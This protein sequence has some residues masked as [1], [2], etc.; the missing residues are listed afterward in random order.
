MS[1]FHGAGLDDRPAVVGRELRVGNHRL[2]A[3]RAAAGRRVGDRRRGSATSGARARRL[4]SGGC[5]ASLSASQRRRAAAA[6]SNRRPRRRRAATSAADRRW[7]RSGPAAG[8]TPPARRAAGR[9][10][11][12][13]RRRR[14]GSSPYSRAS[15][16]PARAA[17]RPGC[18]AL[19]QLVE[20]AELDRLGRARLRAGRGL[21]V[22][23]PVVAQRALL[24]EAGVLG[25]LFDRSGGRSPRTGRR[26][27]VAAAVA[28]V[29]LHDDRAELGPEQ[30][31]RR[32]DVQAGGVVQ[33]LQT[34]GRHQPAEL[35]P[36]AGASGLAAPGGRTSACRARPVGGRACGC[37][38]KAT[39]RQVLALSRPVLSYELPSRSKPSVRDPVP[40]LAGHLAGLAA[41]ADGGV[42]EE[43]LTRRRCCPAGVERPGSVEPNG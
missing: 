29:V 43:A 40:L 23:E 31:A 26:H 5:S 32:A 34:F 9:T 13:R 37:S 35:G 16:T 28:D 20:R 22:A 15:V 1:A 19:P 14:S 24:R 38:M 41:D 18:G 25:A 36:L 33:C 21:V 30:R 17:P 2:L 42:G 10:R 39:C 4:R 3:R 27:A 12:R 8:R 7:S 6:T 11:R